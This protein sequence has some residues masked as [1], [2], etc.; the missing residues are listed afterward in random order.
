VLDR[1]LIAI[2]RVVPHE[3]ATIILVEDSQGRVVRSREQV[4][5]YGQFK[6]PNRKFPLSEFP[7]LVL[8]ANS[9]QPLILTDVRAS[10]CWVERPDTSW[11]RSYLGA[12][13][14]MNGE[15]IGFINLNSASPAFFTTLHAERLAI[16]ADQA[17]IAIDNARLYEQAKELA[18]L[19]ERQRLARDLHDAVSQTLWT[20]SLIADVLPT[21]WAEDH[22]EG[23]RSLSKLQ[24]LT[25]GAVAEMRT[26][27][28]ELRPS[29]LVEATLG[30]LM[31]QLSQAV[32]SGK[33]MDITVTTEG[34]CILPPDVQIG[35]YRLAQ[36]SLNNIAKHSRASEAHI[37]LNGHNEH[38]DLIIQD[39]GRGFSPSEKSPAGFGLGIM[40]ERAEAIGAGLMIESEI[41]HGTRVTIVWPSE[42]NGN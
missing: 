7:D 29:A 16:F 3:T 19:Q 11:V 40:R 35:I 36:E 22:Q 31:E 4:E 39:N 8:M 21:V 23:L 34:A 13:I 42:K 10:P 1:I 37:H 26:L 33:K 15:V 28:L 30:D 25:H 12:P 9:H 6:N 32:M 2:G 38:I 20:A 17:A 24:H 5:A 18:T 14:E 27:L 41:G